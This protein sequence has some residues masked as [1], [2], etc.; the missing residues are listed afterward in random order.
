[1]GYLRP[2]PAKPGH[3]VPSGQSVLVLLGSLEHSL[4][5]QENCLQA[6]LRPLSLC[7]TTIAWHKACNP[8]APA[9]VRY[10]S[11]SGQVRASAMTS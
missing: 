4:G 5:Y 1:M 3:E 2:I 10:W 8:T 6:R 7:R 11:N 9:F